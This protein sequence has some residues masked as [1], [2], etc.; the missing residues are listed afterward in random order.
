MG[1][2]L[3]GHEVARL[4]VVPFLVGQETVN[5]RLR[6]GDRRVNLGETGL[7]GDAPSGQHPRRSRAAQ[8]AA[9][10]RYPMMTGPT[11]V[12]QLAAGCAQRMR[13]YQNCAIWYLSWGKWPW[14][15][16][17]LALGFPAPVHWLV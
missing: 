3:T 8:H 2:S 16:G 1:L 15:L 5:A 11:M 13:L 6:C 9:R 12:K 4:R 10:S 7:C 14:Q 17:S